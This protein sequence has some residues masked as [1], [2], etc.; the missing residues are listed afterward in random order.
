M[1]ENKL[2]CGS[3]LNGDKK[4]N[5]IMW[6]FIDSL[7]CLLMISSSSSFQSL[8]LS[9]G[10]CRV[11]SRWLEPILNYHW[12]DENGKFGGKLSICSPSTIHIQ[13]IFPMIYCDKEMFIFQCLEEKRS[14]AESWELI[15]GRILV[16]KII[17][18]DFPC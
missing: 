1:M 10:W 18:M 15:E 17:N 7:I 14:G 2:S 16:W 9:I 11:C 5:V 13:P 12:I 4:I 8:S 3:N 6:I